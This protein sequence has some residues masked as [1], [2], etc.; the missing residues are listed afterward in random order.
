MGNL[1]AQDMVAQLAWLGSDSLNQAISWHLTSNHFPPVPTTMVAPCIEAIDNAGEIIA[2]VEQVRRGDFA[3][4]ITRKL[5]FPVDSDGIR[6]WG[7]YGEICPLEV[8]RCK[9]CPNKE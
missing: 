5:A 2:K 4:V 8:P 3:Q 9:P 1:Q 6:G 7:I